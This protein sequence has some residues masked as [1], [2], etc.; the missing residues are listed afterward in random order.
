[1]RRQYDFATNY[2]ERSEPLYLKQKVNSTHFAH[3]W[4]QKGLFQEKK[5]G[6]ADSVDVTKCIQQIEIPDLLHMFWATIYISTMEM[7][8]LWSQCRGG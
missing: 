5:I 2:G 3:V 4:I 8:N 6:F 7:S 1:M